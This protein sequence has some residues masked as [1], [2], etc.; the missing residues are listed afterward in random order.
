[1]LHRENATVLACKISFVPLS[2]AIGQEISYA[3][4]YGSELQDRL[5]QLKNYSSLEQ[6][7]K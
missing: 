6:S 5:T 1:M 3:Y 2:R 7:I 4:Q